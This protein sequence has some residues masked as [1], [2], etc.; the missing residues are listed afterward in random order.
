[1]GF[2]PFSRMT[3]SRQT[4]RMVL[5]AIIL[6]T[7]PCYCLGAVM[8]AY[9][10]A[11]G[12]RRTRV[13]DNATLGGATASPRATGTFTPFFTGTPTPFGNQLGA[14]PTQ[15]YLIPTV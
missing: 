11:S 3:D 13:P 6:L 8:L 10:P 5:L 7:L 1:M 2:D 12:P 4:T 14:T 15:I 9:A